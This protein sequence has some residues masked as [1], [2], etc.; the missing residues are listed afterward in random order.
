LAKELGGEPANIA[1]LS[2]NK[3]NTG[4]EDRRMGVIWG[5]VEGQLANYGNATVNVVA[6]GW[7]GWSQEGGLTAMEDLLTAHPDINVVY[8]ENDSMVL[9]AH[10]AIKAAGRD[11]ILILAAADGQK[12]AY[13]LILKGEYGATGLNDPD[14]LSRLA[15]KF[16]LQH[17]RGELPADFP[18][19][20]ITDP[21]VI[22][23]ENIN[24]YYNPDSVF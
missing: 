19:H 4:G 3:G 23:K 10:I 17:S 18:K 8:G 12:E 16:G 11:D 14:I 7:G 24:E 13:E 6:Q 9:G 2:G 22:S 1:I 21:V 20:Y 5:L 15:V